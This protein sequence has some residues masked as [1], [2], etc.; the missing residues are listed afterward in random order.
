MTQLETPRLRLL[1][2]SQVQLQIF[3][4][5][6]ALLNGDLPVPVRPS[7]I[8]PVVA[9]AIRAKLAKMRLASRRDHDWYTYWLIIRKDQDL[10]IGLAGFKGRPNGRDE[11]EIGYGLAPEDQGQGFMTEAA[12]A[13]VNWAL[14]QPICGAV[15]A[16]TEKDNVASHRVLEKIGLVRSGEQNNQYFW[17]IKGGGA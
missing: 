9:R 8:N 10:G 4:D 14:R 6:P 7:I 13:L 16:W 5:D 1:A 3:D 11:V 15:T 17:I 2:L 12:G